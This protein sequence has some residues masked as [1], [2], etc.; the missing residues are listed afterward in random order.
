ME[1]EP[2]R[3]GYRS[4]RHQVLTVDHGCSLS[5]FTAEDGIVMHRCPSIQGDSGGPLLLSRSSHYF[6]M[7]INVAIFVPERASDRVTIA[8]PSVNF[9]EKLTAFGVSGA[10]MSEFLGLAG[11]PGRLAAPSSSN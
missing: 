5:R 8:V 4:D 11:R 3:A 10:P 6:V 1:I 9:S 7:G 2:K